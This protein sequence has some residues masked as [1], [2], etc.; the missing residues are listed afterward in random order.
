[1]KTLYMVIPC[2]NEEPV[3]EET[4]KQL[5]EVYQSMMNEKLISEASRI[6]FVNDGSTDLTW[7]KI[8]ELH[9]QNR[10]FGGINLSRNRG[11]QNAVLAGLLTV[12]DDCDIMI[13]MD[14]DLQDDVAV[15]PEMVRQYNAGFDVVYGVRDN[16]QTDTAFKR[17]T[18]Q[19][20]YKFM[21]L[22]GVETVYN[23]ADFRLMSRRVVEGLAEFGEVNLFLRGM[24]PLVGFP[25][26]NVYYHRKERF[27]GESKYPFTKMLSFAIE[28]IT[29]L[30]IKPMRMITDLGFFVFMMSIVILIYSLVRH[31]TG[32]T[33]VGWTTTVAS[34]WAIGGLIL[35]SQ[36]IIGEYIGK[37]YLETKSRPRFIIES[38]LNNKENGDNFEEESM[39]N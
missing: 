36:G 27:A 3:L 33:I 23:H 11:H 35:L 4:S 6:I 9:N 2:F 13:S 22:M 28:G 32:A 39:E 5:M 20:F 21:S 30:S 12:K 37:I 18:A 38:Y 14:A 8:Q 7:K 29:S 26:T 31:Y 25:S 34:I 10:L 16:R 1:M 19:T 24:I 15:I 17:I